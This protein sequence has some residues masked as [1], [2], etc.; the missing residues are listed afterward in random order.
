MYLFNPDHRDEGNDQEDGKCDKRD[1]VRF[2]GEDAGA[3][4][5]FPPPS[6]IEKLSCEGVGKG[7]KKC[8]KSVHKSDHG[9]GH[10]WKSDF[11]NH[12]EAQ[13]KAADGKAKEK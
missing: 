10:C 5:D 12:R 4:D 2:N 8:I 6:E 7:S 1:F 9:C 13:E 3:I 11:S